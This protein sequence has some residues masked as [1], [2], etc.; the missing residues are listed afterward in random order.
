MTKRK[1]P[2]LGWDAW[3]EQQIEEARA[4]GAFDDLPGAGKPQAEVKGAYDPDW[5]VKQL[6]RR[7]GVSVLPP[8][9]AIRGRVEREVTRIL[10]L[11][12]ESDVRKAVDALNAEIGKVNATVTEGPATAIPRLDPESVLRRWR[13]RVV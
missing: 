10:A 3:I 1:P 2:R 13:E 4:E 6:I 11:P 8:A 9:L 7:E 12:R 5:W